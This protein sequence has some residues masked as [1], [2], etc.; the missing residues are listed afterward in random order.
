MEI[1][2]KLTVRA[3]CLYE[4]LSGKNFYKV[5]NEEETLLLTYACYVTTNDTNVTFNT[6]IK[7]LENKHFANAVLTAYKEIS[8]FTVQLADSGQEETDEEKKD[9]EEITLTDVAS[10]LIIKNGLNPEYVMDKMAFWEI[11]SYF[12]WSEIDYHADM[13]EKRL[14]VYMLLSPMLGKEAKGPEKLIQF[15]WEKESKKEDLINKKE[16]IRNM[17]NS[18]REKRKE[19]EENGTGRLDNT[20]RPQGLDQVD[21]SNQQA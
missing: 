3:G 2:L 15:P 18:F 19:L 21:Q 5:N 13:E 14:W 11:P 10:V 7:M 12:K 17:F 4:K 9:K 1:K 16:F 20:D 8:D 6:F